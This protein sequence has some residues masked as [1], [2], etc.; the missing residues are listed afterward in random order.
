MFL[1]QEGTRS[2]TYV[3]VQADTEIHVRRHEGD[4]IV[5]VRFDD[6]RLVLEFDEEVLPRVVEALTAGK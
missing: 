5:S 1:T 2:R 6:E 4:D 3:H